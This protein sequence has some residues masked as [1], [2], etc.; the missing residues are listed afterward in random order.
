MF[1]FRKK[2]KWHDSNF[3]HPTCVISEHAQIGISN[4]FGPYVVVGPGVTIGDCNRFESHI[5][6]GAPAECWNYFTSH[7]SVLIRDWNI[8]REFV[9]INSGTKGLTYM[10]SHCVFLR[11][12]HLS[13]DT[14]VEDNCVVSCS[15]LIGGESVIM[16]HS[17]LG[18]GSILHQKSVVG[19]YSFIGM[20]GIVTKKSI[21]EPG[22]KYVGNPVRFLTEN[23]HKTQFLKEGQLDVEIARFNQIRREKC[24]Q[25]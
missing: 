13:H 22:K 3:I 19:S 10:G 8:V 12:S 20:G 23:T 16:T 25:P 1:K 24:T 17:N 14:Q 5:S 15:V 2:K 21:I 18:L 11:G 7:G 9:T 4:Y 6:I